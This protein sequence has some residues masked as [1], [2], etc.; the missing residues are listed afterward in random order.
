MLRVVHFAFLI[1]FGAGGFHVGGVF[2]HALPAFEVD[3]RYISVF[4]PDF[5][6]RENGQAGT[7][8]FGAGGI[9]GVFFFGHG[10]SPFH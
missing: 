2:E 4:S 9:D 1:P 6:I 8:A 5:F 3:V 10:G 7:A